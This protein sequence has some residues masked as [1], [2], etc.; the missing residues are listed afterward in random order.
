M[1]LRFTALLICSMRYVLC[2]FTVTVT[3]IHI[4]TFSQVSGVVLAQSRVSAIFIHRAPAR[5]ARGVTVPYYTQLM[6]MMITPRELM[7]L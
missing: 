2:V 6:I 1:A 3:Y 4:H 7:S 5:R